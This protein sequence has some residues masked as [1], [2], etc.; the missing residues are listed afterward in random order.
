MCLHSCSVVSNSLWPHGLQPARLLCPWDFSGK[1][2][3]VGC[4]FRLQG[5]FLPQG[6]NA[7]LCVSCIGTQILYHW[8]T[9]E[10]HEKAYLSKKQ[11]PRLSGTSAPSFLSKY[12]QTTGIRRPPAPT[13]NHILKSK[14]S[15]D[16]QEMF[17]PIS[18][19]GLGWG[20]WK[21][22]FLVSFSKRCT[23]DCGEHFPER[24]SVQP[25]QKKKERKRNIREWKKIEENKN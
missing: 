17:L 2:T 4:H 6:S 19:K 20:D 25:S 24:H 16:R 8:V 18:M 10:A 23:T 15:G 13:W 11:D 21:G 7:Y 9:W 3:G 14:D 12:F 5:I 22:P 1:S